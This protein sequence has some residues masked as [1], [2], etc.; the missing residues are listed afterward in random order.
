MA[1]QPADEGCTIGCREGA[2]TPPCGRGH[3][4]GANSQV[5]NLQRFRIGE[6]LGHALARTPCAG[7]AGLQ[8]PSRPPP[9]ACVPGCPSGTVI[10]T[11]IARTHNTPKP[12][13][14][15]LCQAGKQDLRR[16]VRCLCRVLCVYLRRRDCFHR[17]WNSPR[18]SWTNNS[19][20]PLPSARLILAQS[21]TVLRANSAV[22]RGRLV[23]SKRASDK[24]PL[25]Q[26][27]GDGGGGMP[28][29]A[30]P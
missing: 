18:A 6:K 7:S 11:Q 3:G 12:A 10:V 9:V 28:I 13:K 19:S 8:G 29:F 1:S 23:N 5:Q 24:N 25:F 20:L 21:C 14:H 15:R 30:L 22:L 2:C 27:A 16:D 26:P 4:P 17:V